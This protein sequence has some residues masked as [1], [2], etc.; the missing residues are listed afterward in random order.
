MANGLMLYCGWSIKKLI[1]L[2]QLCDA[3]T[4]SWK[5]CKEYVLGILTREVCIP[6]SNLVVVIF[7]SVCNIF[8]RDNVTAV[9]FLMTM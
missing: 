6:N 9:E 5:A 2:C 8:F 7:L 4:S 3:N 1:Q